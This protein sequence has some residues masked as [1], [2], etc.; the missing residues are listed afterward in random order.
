[1]L[2]LTPVPL[3]AFR[4]PGSGGRTQHETKPC[5]LRLPFEEA[6]KLHPQFSLV[7]D[8]RVMTSRPVRGPARS[9]RGLSGT[10]PY[11]KPFDQRNVRQRDVTRLVL[12]ADH[13]R[14]W[15]ATS[16]DR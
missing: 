9:D 15:H 13:M 1:V 4:W 12:Q 14:E 2:A 10:R 7:R 11:R 3:W 5:R 6:H 8:G 16:V